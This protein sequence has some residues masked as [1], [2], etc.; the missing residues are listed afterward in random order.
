M[1]EKNAIRVDQPSVIL[2]VADPRLRSEYNLEASQEDAFLVAFIEPYDP[3]NPIMWPTVQKWAITAVL[4]ATGF[5]RI[6]VSTMLAPA[7]PNIASELHMNDLE[8]V[9]ALSA[10]MLSTAFGPLV[11]A[12]LFE[13]YGRRPVLHA[14]NVWALIW[15]LVCGFAHNKGLLIAARLLAG[16]GA[17]AIY[18]LASGVLGDVWPPNQRGRS[19]ALYN[20]VPLLGAAVGPIVGGFIT[21]RTTWRWMFW[22]M[23]ALQGCIAI[24][25]LL[26]LKETYGPIILQKKAAHL[27]KVKEDSRYHTATEKL[28]EGSS[29]TQVFRR[30]LSRPTRLLLYHPIVQVQALLSAFNY[31]MTYL[32]IS[33]YS[34]LWISKYHQ[35]I[36]TSGL[37]YIAM[38]FGEVLGSAVGGTLMDLVFWKLKARH[39]GATSP[40]FRIPIMF[41]AMALTMTGLFLYGWS[42][43]AHAFWV[44]V[45]TGAAVLSFGMTVSGMAIQA[46]VID[47][48][49]DHVSSASAGTQLLRSLAAFGFPLFA[50]AMYSSLG[51][52][53]ANTLLAL[54][55]CVV[56]FPAITGIWLYGAKLRAKK[57]SSY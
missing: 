19:L 21:Q 37:H 31:G 28:S 29:A 10:Y 52:G 4:S 20:L 27:R 36:S 18:V 9:M 46:Y 23:S 35:S 40:E 56:S 14:T 3:Q 51:Y 11:I 43:Q 41:P 53:W 54:T 17:G 33:T 25:S 22:S 34:T 47:S 55:S 57:P 13:V 6:M 39:G 38:C 5:V 49:P 30:S 7:L 1:D 2:A 44:L 42:A 12:P 26:V 48:Y 45:D 32:V 16:F 50:P 8:A 24:A 15:N